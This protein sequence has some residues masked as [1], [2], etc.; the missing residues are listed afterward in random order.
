MVW[1]LLAAGVVGAV[2]VV[3]GPALLG[4]ADAAEV[5]GDVV[6]AAFSAIG[7]AFVGAVRGAYES[8]REEIDGNEAE[9]VAALTVGMIAVG[10]VWF[11]WNAVKA[12]G[13]DVC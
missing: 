12:L 13:S 7:P 5:T 9:A 6:G 3:A 11:G 1:P 10:G 4:G 2:S 8:I